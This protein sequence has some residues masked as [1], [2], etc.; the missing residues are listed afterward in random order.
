MNQPVQHPLNRR[1]ALIARRGTL[2]VIIGLC[3]ALTGL[4]GCDNEPDIRVYE[5]NAEQS[6]AAPT[7]GPAAV[8]APATAPAAG[9]NQ[10]S[11]AGLHWTL[12][13]GWQRVAGER[14]MRLATFSTTV[15][16]PLEVALSRFPGDTGG[17]LA[18]V[19]RWRGQVGLAAITDND[20]AGELKPAETATL[21]GHTMRLR[22]SAQHLLGAILSPADGSETWFVKAV[23][24]PAAIDAHEAE[25]GAFVASLG[26]GAASTTTTRP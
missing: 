22:G 15:G 25:F 23:G 11:V 6:S 12:P 8:R 26:V 9:T 7:S 24:T 1:R 21:R 17:L 14:P 16:E 10:D 2:P 18:N 19:N 5:V 20:L 3:V 13:A 4:G